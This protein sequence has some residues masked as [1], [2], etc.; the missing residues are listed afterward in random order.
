[1]HGAAAF[2]AGNGQFGT[3]IMKPILAGMVAIA[4]LASAASGA[5]AQSF[6]CRKA[7][8]ADEK[9]ICMNPDLSRLDE[10]L[11]RI[12]GQN[13]NLLSAAGRNAL[14]RE[15]ERWVVARRRCGPDHRCIEDS[16]RDRIGELGERL[17]EAR[18]D[19]R[20]EDRRDDWGEARR[21]D[22]DEPP[23]ARREPWRE[24]PPPERFAPEPPAASREQWRDVPPLER[25]PP[26]PPRTESRRERPVAPSR[27]RSDGSEH[28]SGREA[29]A[30][31]PTRNSSRE[32]G[33]S[34]A[35]ETTARRTPPPPTASEPH[36]SAPVQ[37]GKAAQPGASAA[38]TA[39]EPRPRQQAAPQ[40]A[41]TA[42][43]P[44]ATTGSSLHPPRIEFDDPASGPIPPA[45]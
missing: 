41:N 36:R 32:E 39:P 8:F 28:P 21:D 35:E 31:P 22:W 20:A 1:M 3:V 7:N 2:Y 42:P 4:A 14:D 45:R 9:L 30:P 6:N 12:F 40:P 16:Y 10:R 24:A 29:A 27:A 17:G 11:N 26:E 19:D 43:P 15:E 37:A 38:V 5:Q 33:A 13:R 23:A 44:E 18:R 25:F 34:R